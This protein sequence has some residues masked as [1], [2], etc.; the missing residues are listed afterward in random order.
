VLAEGRHQD[1]S[2]Q[3][4]GQLYARRRLEEVV[5]QPDEREHRDQRQ[6]QP[7]LAQRWKRHHQCRV[8]TQRQRQATG[9]RHRVAVPL[10][11]PGMVDQVQPLRRPAQQHN[12]QHRQT[13]G[14]EGWNKQM[15]LAGEPG[16]AVGRKLCRRGCTPA[17]RASG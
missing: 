16:G 5:N 12:Q 11:S 7:D 8:E 15:H 2:E 13:A 10:A 9:Q 6:Q 14:N 3:L 1:S 4:H 17:D